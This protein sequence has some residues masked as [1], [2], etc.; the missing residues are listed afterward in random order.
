MSGDAE[1]MAD[2]EQY[3]DVR[4][5]L[6]EYEQRECFNCGHTWWRRSRA[7]ESICSECFMGQGDHER[8]DGPTDYG[9][10]W[11]GDVSLEEKRRQHKETRKQARSLTG[12]VEVRL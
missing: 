7:A 6:R 1:E 5:F 3:T 2:L 10:L 11:Y 4:A 9:T 12:H 8:V